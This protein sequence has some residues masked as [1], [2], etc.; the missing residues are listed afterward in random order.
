[1]NPED[2]ER[3]DLNALF[4]RCLEQTSNRQEPVTIRRKR[5]VL[6]RKITRL[7]N[8]P[9]TWIITLSLTAGIGL[10]YINVLRRENQTLVQT[11]DSIREWWNESQQD[12]LDEFYRRLAYEERLAE[13]AL[14][15]FLELQ[16]RDRFSGLGRKAQIERSSTYDEI[17]RMCVELHQNSENK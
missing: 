11:V 15:D 13:V 4:R 16:C 17:K 12:Y 2:Q 7:L 10:N 6:R 1:M 8:H 3:Q 5:P 9:G 14:P